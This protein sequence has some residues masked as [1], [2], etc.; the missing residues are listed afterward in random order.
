MGQIENEGRDDVALIGR[1]VAR[2]QRAMAE[3]YDR[4]SRLLY[5]LI[6]RIVREQREAEDVLEEVFLAVWRRADR[7]NETSGS[8]AAWL[9]RLARERAIDRLRAAGARLRAI[10][11]LVGRSRDTSSVL[12]ALPADQRPLVED[13]YFLGLSH[14]ELAVRFQLPLATVQ[15]RVRAAMLSLRQLLEEHV[16]ER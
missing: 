16:I 7:Y 10:D 11:D 6:V 8:P 13:A 12:A 4:Y 2:D 5:G 1:L 9:V 14:S 3:L 15:T